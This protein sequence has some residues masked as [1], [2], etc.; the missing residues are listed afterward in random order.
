MNKDEVLTY[1]NTKLAK[2]LDNWSVLSNASSYQHKWGTAR[3][4]SAE[5]LARS[6]LAA[7]PLIVA[8]NKFIQDFYSEKLVSFATNKEYA[9][10]IGVYDQLTVEVAGIC[11]CMLMLEHHNIDIL[12]KNRSLVVNWIS[13]YTAASF[14][15]NNWQMF[16]IV[17]KHWVNKHSSTNFSTLEHWNIIH[18]C[19]VGNGFYTDGVNGAIDYYNHWGF[20]WYSMILVNTSD[21]F[22]NQSILIDRSLLL[23]SKL[24]KDLSKGPLPIVGRSQCY[25]EAASAILAL[26]HQHKAITGGHFLLE[27]NLNQWRNST[28][29]S[30]VR[31]DFYSCDAS[32]MWRFKWMWQGL[33]KSDSS[34]WDNY[35][36]S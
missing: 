35:E 7:V 27:K 26:V 15:K 17:I 19:Y 14:I 31:K 6:F 18:K 25:R 2:V 3:E 11:S 36:H 28:G 10:K 5:V 30:D 22:E 32:E 8:G 9:P 16:A 23:A 34:W 24:I 13:L 33:I 4:S 20:H 21:Q 1:A 29:F 12:G